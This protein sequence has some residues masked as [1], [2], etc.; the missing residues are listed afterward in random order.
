[1]SKSIH[2]V[3]VEVCIKVIFQCSKP[4]LWY[5]EIY[6]YDLNKNLVSIFYLQIKPDSDVSKNYYPTAQTLLLLATTRYHHCTRRL[7]TS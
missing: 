4:K 6:V 1:M 5:N 2:Q 3:S 7:T